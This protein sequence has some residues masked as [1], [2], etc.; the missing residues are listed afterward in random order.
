[1]SWEGSPLSEVPVLLMLAMGGKDFSASD[2]PEVVGRR[3]SGGSN[4]AVLLCLD[5]M[6]R[7]FFDLPKN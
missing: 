1:M 3:L 2:G 5:L 4:G 7:R 6:F